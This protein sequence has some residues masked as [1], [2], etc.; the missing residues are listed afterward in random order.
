MHEK[1]PIGVCL[2]LAFNFA[3]YLV[4]QHVFYKGNIRILLL[5][6]VVLVCGNVMVRFFRKSYKVFQTCTSLNL[7]CNLR[8]VTKSDYYCV[9]F[10]RL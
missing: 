5:L 6:L 2:V 1:Q 9:V 7:C 8:I 4:M 3:L 10:H